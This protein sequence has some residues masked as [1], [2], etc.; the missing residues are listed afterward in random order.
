MTPSTAEIDHAER[1]IEEANRRLDDIYDRVAFAEGDPASASSE[2]TKVDRIVIHDG[3]DSTAAAVGTADGPDERVNGAVLDAG[4][5]QPHSRVQSVIMDCQLCIELAVEAVFELAG[6]DGTFSRRVPFEDG[7][8]VKLYG[9]L[10]DDFDRKND[11]VRVVFLTQ[12]WCEF[13][14]LVKYGAPSAN[15]Q[16]EQIFESDDGSR[17][18]DDA[19]YCIEIARELL[20]HVRRERSTE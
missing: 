15:V 9:E 16:P 2:E 4:R 19:E 10:P 14:E 13:N 7:R 3:A 1:R 6:D 8:D 5:E 11:V 20:E 12:F 18:V 17:A